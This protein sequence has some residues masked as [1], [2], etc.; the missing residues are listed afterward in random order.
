[1]LLAYI[2]SDV[3][4]SCPQMSDQQDETSHI[5]GATP[6]IQ[7]VLLIQAHNTGSLNDRLLRAIKEAVHGMYIKKHKIHVSQTL[8]N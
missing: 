8:P 5:H 4:C 3:A 6:G 1:M 7:N 2:G